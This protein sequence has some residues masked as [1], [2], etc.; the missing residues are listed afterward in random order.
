M[1]SFVPAEWKDFLVAATSAAAALS[2]L[3]FVGLSINLARIMEGRG[4][5]D[6]AAETLILLSATLVAALSGLVPEP[7]RVTAFIW[8]GVGAA[9][10][11][12]VT[13]LHVRALRHH[14]YAEPSHVWWRIGLTQVAV[15]PLLIG[16][17]SFLAE[18]GG[19]LHWLA[20]ALIF[21]LVISLIN[22]W[23]LLVEILR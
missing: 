20:P 12:I 18:R 5:P 13:R 19:G 17:L 9:T 15:L 23:V 22:A 16:P 4:L 8:L 1:Y 7:R 10:W 21:P 2:G 3:L 14:L 11:M 6:R